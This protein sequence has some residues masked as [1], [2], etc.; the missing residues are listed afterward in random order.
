MLQRWTPKPI[1]GY[2]LSFCASGKYCMIGVKERK[3]IN[4]KTGLLWGFAHLG[5][6]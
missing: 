6:G 4:G 1:F 2:A 3:I 5:L